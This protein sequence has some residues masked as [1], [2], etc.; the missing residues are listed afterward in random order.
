MKWLAVE[1]NL[2][3]KAGRTERQLFEMPKQGFQALECLT[4][5]LDQMEH[6]LEVVQTDQP[7]LVH[8]VEVR[9]MLSLSA[10]KP[11]KASLVGASWNH[12]T[13]QKLDGAGQ[14]SSSACEQ[15]S[16][17]RASQGQAAK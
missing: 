13:T 15:F 16:P 14:P 2:G 17:P 5:M 10:H 6:W 11:S 7:H 3:V 1:H 9:L 4:E 8:M 12:T